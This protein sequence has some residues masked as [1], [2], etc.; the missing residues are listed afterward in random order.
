MV[1]TEDATNGRATIREVY[2][3][4][5]RLRTE[6]GAHLSTIEEKLDANQHAMEQRIRTLEAWR[7][8]MTGVGAAVTLALSIAMTFLARIAN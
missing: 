8:W 3:L 1:V 7:A 2:G 6:I 4:M 5:D